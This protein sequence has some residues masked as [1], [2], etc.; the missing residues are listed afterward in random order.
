MKATYTRKLR[1]IRPHKY[2]TRHLVAGEEYEVPIRQAIALVVSRR[3]RFAPKP[4]SKRASMAPSSPPKPQAEPQAEPMDDRID[5]LRLEAMA[6]GIV[7]DGRWGSL[8]LAQEIEQ[9]RRR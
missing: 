1:A 7:V 6:L 5:R 8:R 4:S 3:A 9:A 2:G